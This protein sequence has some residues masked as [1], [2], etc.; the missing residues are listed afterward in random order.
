MRRLWHHFPASFSKV[1]KT[2]GLDFNYFMLLCVHIEMVQVFSVFWQDVCPLL[3]EGLLPSCYSCKRRITG[4]TS[5]L[6][7]KHEAHGVHFAV[8]WKKNGP[9]SVQFITVTLVI[10]SHSNADGFRLQ[11]L[12]II[13]LM[14]AAVLHNTAIFKHSSSQ[15]PC[16]FV[17][18]SRVE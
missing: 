7:R 4:V 8:S 15:S 17:T 3:T 13:H 10:A 2:E 12:Y 5:C 18:D 16:V 9:F 14:F 6:F 11:C 1:R